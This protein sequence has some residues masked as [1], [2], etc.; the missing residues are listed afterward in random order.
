M[1]DA[2]LARGLPFVAGLLFTLLLLGGSIW[3]IRRLGIGRSR[4]GNNERR[5]QSRL[6]VIEAAAAV[7]E[8]RRLILIRR[9]NVEHL[10]MIGGPTDVVIEPNIVRA[11]V[12]TREWPAPL[13]A[14]ETTD[15]L[16]R[17][18][19][20]G[21]A[22]MWPLQAEPERVPRP[23]RSPAPEEP[24]QWSV[25]PELPSPPAPRRQSRPIDPFAGLAAEVAR[26]P[27]PTRTPSDLG[28]PGG[29]LP[30][31]PMH[32]RAPVLREREPAQMREP[33]PPPVVAEPEI[34]ASVDQNLADMMH[35][36]EAALSRPAETKTARS[37]E[38]T[39]RPMAAEPISALPGRPRAAAPTS[40]ARAAPSEPKP[41]ISIWDNLEKEMASVW[42]TP[43]LIEDSETSITAAQKAMLRAIEEQPSPS[44]TVLNSDSVDVGAFAPESAQPGSVLKPI[45]DP[46][47]A[48]LSALLRDDHGLA[49]PP[50]ERGHEDP[51]AR[52]KRP[53]SERH[54]PVERKAPPLDDS[55]DI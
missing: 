14:P 13:R 12:A 17:A 39:P 18:V 51:A 15:T 11:A 50:R 47:D 32:E 36:L 7:G 52:R 16:T 3:A 5:K 6:A 40:A 2:L 1:L 44:P 27:E 46:E 53:L 21:D 19:P 29:F 31:A 38:S 25:E 37:A 30:R 28:G 4:R 43:A 45:V 33:P 22:G 48:E 24:V 41:S 23:Q 26:L 8:R 20:L 9:D 54:A 10:L 49:E 42:G 34:N 55:E 35:R